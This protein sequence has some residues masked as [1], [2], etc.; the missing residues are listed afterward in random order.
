MVE[1]PIRAAGFLFISTDFEPFAMASGTPTQKQE[2]PT[3]AAGIL[4]MRTL[5]APVVIGPPTCGIGGV[6]GVCMGHVCISET[7]A[8]NGIT[9][10]L[11]LSWSECRK[12]R[13]KL[14]YF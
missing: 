5:G 10:V 9:F 3:V 6:P 14:F 4:P 7:L 1:S 13:K 8:A 11:A 2:L 12:I